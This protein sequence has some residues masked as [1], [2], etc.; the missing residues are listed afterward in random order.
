MRTPLLATA[1]WAAGD[2]RRHPGAALLTG[3]AL[4]A[5]VAVLATVLMLVEAWSA[6]SRN[7]VAAG[8]SLVVRRVDAGGW[9][10]LE[11]DAGV[12]AARGVV[13]VLDARPRV[14]GLVAGPAGALTVLGV[15]EGAAAGLA[16]AGVPRPGPGEAVLGGGVAGAAAGTLR[17]EGASDRVL[18]VVA[19]LDDA[20]ALGFHDV[21]LTDVADARALLGL[22]AGQASDLAVDVYHESEETA[23]LPDLSE[24]F[25]W[26]VRITTRTEAAGA[27]VAALTVRG[28]LVTV[29]YVPA[30]L[31]MVLL[32]VTALRSRAGAARE[33]G[34]YKALGWTTAD[35]VTLQAA[36]SLLVGVPAVALGLT[37]AWVLVFTPG[38]VWPGSLLLGWSAS[39]PPLNLE[40]GSAVVVALTVAAMVLVPWT[41]AS[42][43][44]AVRS[45][46]ADPDALVRGVSA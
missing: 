12:A 36:R 11:V 6:T 24:A 41:L 19:V 21:V 29:L 14:W 38:T 39:P 18:T 5:L 3:L 37:V 43:L 9:R 15:D 28:G 25:P 10:P 40:P 30:L 13:G 45:A 8:P 16:R 33:L 4:M 27:A 26:P 20:L 22:A 35:L 2:L 7:L 23:I 46:T 42:L 44:P 1:A 17:L 34:L 32:V 31:A